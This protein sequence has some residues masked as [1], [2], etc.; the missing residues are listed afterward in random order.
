MV[1]QGSMILDPVGFR[2]RIVRV[3]AL[4]SLVLAQAQP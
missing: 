2:V 1:V 3:G 4:P